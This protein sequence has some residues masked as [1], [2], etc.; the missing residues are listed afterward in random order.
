MWLELAACALIALQA[1]TIVMLGLQGR[2]RRGD[3]V[4]KKDASDVPELLILNTLN[5]IDHRL[6]K[7]E[8]RLRHEADAVVPRR[9]T[10]VP[11]TPPAAWRVTHA[12]FSGNHYELAQQLAREGADLEQL[13]V[14]CGLS[15][16]EAELVQRLYAKRA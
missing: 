12:P 15:R 1:V 7:L 2:G 8:E 10:E 5:N 16:N 14:R 4:A 3:R 11:A 9:S 6:S 13:M